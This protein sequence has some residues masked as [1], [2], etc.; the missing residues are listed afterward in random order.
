MGMICTCQLVLAGPSLVLHKLAAA[1]STS[2]T[3]H[4]LGNE[5]RG[6]F[7][8]ESR[9][10]LDLSIMC[11]P[12]GVEL[13]VCQHLAALLV[14]ETVRLESTRQHE[15]MMPQLCCQ[16]PMLTML[17]FVTLHLLLSTPLRGW[18]DPASKQRASIAHTTYNIS[19]CSELA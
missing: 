5:Q 2:W 15:T 19:G 6:S 12:A 17:P 11:E 18:A 13:L 7:Q 8:G 16:Q 9:Q 1:C 4:W 3:L 14:Q 10:V